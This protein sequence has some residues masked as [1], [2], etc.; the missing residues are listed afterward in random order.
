MYRTR[1]SFFWHFSIHLQNPNQFTILR[2][3]FSSRLPPET[4]HPCSVVNTSTPRPSA[5]PGASP[6]LRPRQR[7]QGI[8][9]GGEYQ[10]CNPRPKQ[11]IIQPYVVQQVSRYI[12]Y[13]LY[14]PYVL[15]KNAY[16]LSCFGLLSAAFCRVMAMA[17]SVFLPQS[18]PNSPKKT[19]TTI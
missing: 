2:N 16:V 14:V 9:G 17:F 5:I 6:V 18:N 4:L 8:G 15:Q 12:D 10:L 11:K 13:K 3:W 1:N 19:T 7:I